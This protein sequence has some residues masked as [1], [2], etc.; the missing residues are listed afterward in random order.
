MIGRAVSEA[1]IDLNVS[2]SKHDS[3]HTIVEV[4][5]AR[6]QPYDLKLPRAPS[7]QGVTG[8]ARIGKNG[9]CTSQT[10]C[11]IQRALAVLFEGLEL[12]NHFTNMNRGKESLLNIKRCTNQSQRIHQFAVKT[13]K[14]KG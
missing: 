11:A 4:Y 5:K 2:C 1:F 13:S 12:V 9:L 6:P 7:G 10:E 14:S 8:E 3:V